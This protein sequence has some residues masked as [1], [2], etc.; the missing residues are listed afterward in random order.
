MTRWG[1]GCVVLSIGLLSSGCHPSESSVASSAKP[2]G[3]TDSHPHED[4]SARA[5]KGNDENPNETDNESDDDHDDGPSSEGAHWALDDAAL[6]AKV[7]SVI[8]K[9]SDEDHIPGISITVV[10]DKRIVIQKGYGMADIDSKTPETKDT[11]GAVASETKIV[12]TVAILQ[13]VEA[14]K[15]SLEDPISKYLKDAPAIWGPI[16][17][18]Q[19]LAMQSGIPHTKK[20]PEWKEQVAWAAAR[21]LSFP[22]GTKTDYSNTSFNVLGE[23]IEAASGKGYGDYLAEHIFTPLKM[24]STRLHGP[25]DPTRATGYAWK[26]G[27][28]EHA[29]PMPPIGYAAGGLISNQV[30]MSLFDAGLESSTLLKKE[31]ADLMYTAQ[32]LAGGKKGM[33]GLGWDSV[34]VV[35][36]KRRVTKGGDAPG[37]KAFWARAI[38]EGVSVIVMGNNDNKKL[39]G[40]GWSIFADALGRK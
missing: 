5:E 37:Y 24:T 31:T 13:L 14:K 19:L 33:R 6:Q 26:K 15:L 25:S 34:R 20:P 12:T 3:S 39:N 30:D 27:S 17:I 23:I 40:V 10:R 7:D 8:A 11:M 36:G 21:P 16:T 1:W 2:A 22:P 4:K 35:K 9:A 32:D 18:R 29:P 28:L 38:D